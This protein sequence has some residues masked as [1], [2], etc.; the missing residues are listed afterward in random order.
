VIR[1]IVKYGHPVLHAPAQPVAQI[2]DTVR[3]LVDDMV[4]TMYAAPG[5]GL[6]ATQIGVP[7][8]VLVIDISVGRQPGSLI[9]LINPT[10]VERDGIL[11]EEEGCLS[12]PGYTA[13]VD[14]HARVV[15][16]GTA[17]DGTTV[18]HEATG[19]LARAFQHEMDHLDGRLYVD[20]LRGIKRQL[21]LRGISK[22]QRQGK[23]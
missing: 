6:A 14:R 22:Q 16:E 11:Y 8:R 9:Q 3:Q 12:V 2:D 7:A 4:E 15:V 19:L 10:F 1:E 13:R 23:W 5:I 18:R 20:H 17:R 21:I